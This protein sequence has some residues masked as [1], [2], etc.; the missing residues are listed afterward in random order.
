MNARHVCKTTIGKNGDLEPIIS[1][2]NESQVRWSSLV[3]TTSS[4]SNAKWTKF[5]KRSLTL[6]HERCLE[7]SL[8]SSLSLSLYDL[9][10]LTDL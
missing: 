1:D 8:K 2:Q 10:K 3:K 4:H 6:L 7:L 9:Y 5:S